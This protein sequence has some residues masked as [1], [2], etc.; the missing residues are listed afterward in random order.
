MKKKLKKLSLGRE[1]LKALT[2]PALFEVAA[3]G[4]PRGG[5]PNTNTCS[6]YCRDASYCACSADAC[7]VY[8][9]QWC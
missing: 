1:T 5:D 7:T 2:Q 6:L 3:G 4:P 9:T 8:V